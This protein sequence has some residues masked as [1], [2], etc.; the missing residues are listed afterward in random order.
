MLWSS[1]SGA[2]SMLCKLRSINGPGC[3]ALR[4]TPIS[5]TACMAQHVYAYSLDRERAMAKL[6]GLPVPCVL[7]SH[8]CYR[9][10]PSALAMFMA[11]PVAGV[12]SES[13]LSSALLSRPSISLFMSSGRTQ[14]VLAVSLTRLVAKPCINT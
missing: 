9:A 12:Y 2:C 1:S 7:L 13:P 14:I 5:N 10:A 8:Q 11:G 4:S 3:A 6:R